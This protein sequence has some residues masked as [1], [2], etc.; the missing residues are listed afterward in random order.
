MNIMKSGLCSHRPTVN[1]NINGVI[2]DERSTFTTLRVCVFVFS[3]ARD[4]P[5]LKL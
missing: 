2:Q 4:G 1:N 5:G 3:Y